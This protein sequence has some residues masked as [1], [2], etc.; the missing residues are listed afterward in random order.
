VGRV[1]SAFGVPLSGFS[2]SI[3]V[4]TLDGRLLDANEQERLGSQIR[5]VTPGYFDA[6]GM[7]LVR[8]RGITTADRAGART[9]AVINETA[10][11][12]L[13]GAEDPVGKHIS[14]G[15]RLGL[16]G[17]RLN[18]E[19]V[20]LV[21][22]VKDVALRSPARPHV[23]FA[24]AQWPVNFLQPVIR[25]AGPPLALAEAARRAVAQVDPDVPVYDVRSLTQL[26]AAST[27]RDRFVMLVLGVF[28]SAA[29]SLAAVGIY[30]VV[31]H[32]VGQRR[33]ELGIRLALGARAADIV[34]LV[35]SQGAVMAGAGSA[36][37]L[38]GALVATRALR[39]LL[40]R[41]TPNDPSTL[42]AGTLVLLL[43]ALLASYVPARRASRVNPVE[44]LRHE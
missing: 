9:V 43:V 31:A 17:D 25:T 6:I 13:F 34:R 36:L 19:I 42:T 26:R 14:F 12:N 29:L 18:G 10:A 5:I 44:A 8:G 37:G 23:Y 39:G 2:H 21:R 30:G 3:S 32:A 28:A 27:A 35:L 15:T 11:R 1:G 24:H 7:N 4:F 41:T 20:G 22:D 16:G 40:Y 33:R 38:A